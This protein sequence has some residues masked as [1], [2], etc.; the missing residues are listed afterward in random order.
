[1]KITDFRSDK[2][3]KTEDSICFCLSSIAISVSKVYVELDGNAFFKD[4]QNCKCLA[5]YAAAVT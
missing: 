3:K 1:M 5:L 2:Y 4:I